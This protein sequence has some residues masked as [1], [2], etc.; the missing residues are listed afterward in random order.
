[1]PKV[2]GRPKLEAAAQPATPAEPEW[3]RQT[4]RVFKVQNGT[5]TTVPCDA[6]VYGNVVVHPDPFGS[7]WAV[8]CSPLGARLALLDTDEDAVR[9]AEYLWATCRAA[10]AGKTESVVKAA[11]PAWVKEW[12]LKLNKAGRWVDPPQG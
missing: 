11:V 8:T 4:V 1:M 3:V 12:C 2:T 10:L 5:Y 9:V 7:K 6:L